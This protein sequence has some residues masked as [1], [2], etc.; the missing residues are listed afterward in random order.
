MECQISQ[1]HKKE[2]LILEGITAVLKEVQVE[3]MVR[4]T[5]VQF[6]SLY[7]EKV[8]VVNNGQNN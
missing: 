7:L 8:E 5:R 2:I 1:I 3:D 6:I 4:L